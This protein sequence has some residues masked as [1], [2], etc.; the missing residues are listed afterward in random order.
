MKLATGDNLSDHVCHH[1]DFT[2]EETEARRPRLAQLLGGRASPVAPTVECSSRPS[3]PRDSS[4]ECLLLPTADHMALESWNSGPLVPY[5][6][7]EAKGPHDLGAASQKQHS[8]VLCSLSSLRQHRAAWPPH[9]QALLSPTVWAGIGVGFRPPWQKWVGMEDPGIPRLLASSSFLWT[10]VWAGRDGFPPH[11]LSMAPA[12]ARS[13]AS[14][15]EH[16][17]LVP[18]GSAELG[19][20]HSS[21]ALPPASWGPQAVIRPPF[22]SQFLL[23]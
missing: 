9:Q 7:A 3:V 23:R 19:D 1:P 20:L 8:R 10:K 11:P 21:P 2:R 15:P 4:A 18:G 16:Q 6:S 5:L 22:A 14:L 17:E 12:A 13:S